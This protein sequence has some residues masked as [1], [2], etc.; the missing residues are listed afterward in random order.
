M[1]RHVVP[2]RHSC[3][4]SLIDLALGI[5]ETTQSTCESEYAYKSEKQMLRMHEIARKNIKL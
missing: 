3:Y 1:T 5:P 2:P 4:S